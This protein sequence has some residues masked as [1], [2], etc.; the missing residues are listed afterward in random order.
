MWASRATVGETPILPWSKGRLKPPGQAALPSESTP[1]AVRSCL[2]LHGF[3]ACRIWQS[4]TGGPPEGQRA[5][6]QECPARLEG[7]PGWTRATL[8][9][10]FVM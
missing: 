8:T 5:P 7:L 9:L 3:S 4:D 1:S 10:D 6:C 2:D